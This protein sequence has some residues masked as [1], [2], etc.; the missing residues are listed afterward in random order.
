[1]KIAFDRSYN[2]IITQLRDGNISPN[3]SKNLLEKK[4]LIEDIST[5]TNI[6]SFKVDSSGRKI[7][8]FGADPFLKTDIPSQ[9]LKNVDVQNRLVDVLKDYSDEDFQKKLQRNKV[10]N[11]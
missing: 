8:S 9:M 10:L 11:L 2:N 6:G 4:K 1:M 7:L 3:I 5:K